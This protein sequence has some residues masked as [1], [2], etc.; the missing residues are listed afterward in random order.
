MI[1][2]GVD[3]LAVNLVDPTAAAT[4]ISKA[5]D[6]D[7][8]VVFFN[9]EPDHSVLASYD[10]AWYV[11]TNSA[12]AG[13]IQGE[14]MVKD[15]QANADWDLNGDGVVQYVMLK[16]EPG[17]PDAE[18]RTLEAVKAF[19]DAGIEVEK[20]YEDTAMWDSAQANDKLSSWLSASGADIELVITNND[21]MALGAIN[22]METAGY[23]LPVYGVDAIPDALV[24]IE[25]GQM[26]GTVLNDAKNQGKAT[27]ELAYNVAMGKDVLDG[28]EW[29][30]DETK[31]VRVPYVQVTIDNID[32]GKKAYE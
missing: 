21:G 26:N 9:K 16:G 13:I 27:F 29:T 17:H 6:A 31:S 10:K 22:A 1:A 12:E 24:K 30:L 7:L 8:P 25:A 23:A 18:A 14:M 20:L 15:W 19:T 11:G 2:K 4:I 5:K 32:F 28:T 3:S